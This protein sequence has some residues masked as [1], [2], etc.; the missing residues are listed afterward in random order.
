MGRRA[1]A[2]VLVAATLQ[3]QVPGTSA[4][5]QTGARVSLHREDFAVYQ[6]YSELRRGTTEY[7]ELI[8]ML[9]RDAALT[10]PVATVQGITPATG[11]LEVPDGLTFAKPQYPKP[12]KRRF[13]F[14][15]Q[16]IPVLGTRYSIRLK[17]SAAKDAHLGQRIVTGK[18]TY[19]TIDD[20]GLSA[21]QQIDVD[22]PVTTVDHK[23]HVH[24]TK[25]FPLQI[26]GPGLVLI[27]V[28]APFLISFEIVC[29][30]LTMGSQ[31]CG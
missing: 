29:S 2:I 14:A 7:V 6:Y 11:E 3:V 10:S 20:A 17:V 23:K 31:G 30:I 18:L 13:K 22:I 21:V 16:P 15:A 25:D 4:E 5:S 12:Y 9:P 8:P 1:C 27:F 19:Q 28:L 26:S 24:K